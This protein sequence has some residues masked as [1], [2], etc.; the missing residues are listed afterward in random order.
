[1]KFSR[2]KMGT[3]IRDR[4]F[5]LMHAYYRV[6]ISF[7]FLSQSTSSCQIVETIRPFDQDEVGEAP[8]THS[9]G[10]PLMPS[11]SPL[12]TSLPF[13][14]VISCEHKKEQDRYSKPHVSFTQILIKHRI[15]NARCS[16][17]PIFSLRPFHRWGGGQ[18]REVHMARH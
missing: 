10:V 4:S 9:G 7:G 14:H 8:H 18:T 1:M 15:K 3:V 16:Q 5:L 11:F 13:K 6:C 12:L 17:R 2:S